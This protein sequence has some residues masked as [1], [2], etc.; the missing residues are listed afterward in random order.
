MRWPWRLHKE[1]DQRARQARAEVEKSRQ[2]LHE[3]R[4]ESVVSRTF[5]ERNHFYDILRASLRE[6]HAGKD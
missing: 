4:A 5:R 1:W 6:G 2:A 3:T